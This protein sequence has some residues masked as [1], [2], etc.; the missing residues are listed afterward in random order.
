MLSVGGFLVQVPLCLLL[1]SVECWWPVSSNVG[2]AM[3]V[4]GE[5]MR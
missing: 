1:V 3:P 5:W 4:V 2:A